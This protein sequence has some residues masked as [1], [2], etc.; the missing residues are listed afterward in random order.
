M[1]FGLTVFYLS[2][3]FGRQFSERLFEISMTSLYK[4]I[5]ALTQSTKHTEF[6]CIDPPMLK[7]ELCDTSNVQTLYDQMTRFHFLI[8]ASILSSLFSYPSKNPHL[9]NDTWT[10]IRSAMDSFSPDIHSFCICE[11][12]FLV[13]HS[14]IQI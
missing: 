7:N 11:I 2:M 5:T 9:M 12:H 13:F 10:L 6:N 4:I 1:D 3:R 14:T 8:V